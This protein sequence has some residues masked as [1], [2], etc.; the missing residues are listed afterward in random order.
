MVKVEN[1]ESINEGIDFVIDNLETATTTRTLRN[2]KK[3][4][5]YSLKNEYNIKDKD[6]LNE[7]S[8]FIL[9]MNGL[10]NYNFDF[11]R[12]IIKVFFDSQ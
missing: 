1:I 11:V 10:H 5:I 3:A 8:D 2:I 12:M 7:L 9:K 6:Q 4:L